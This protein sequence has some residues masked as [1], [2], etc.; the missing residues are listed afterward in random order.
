MDLYLNIK[1]R[2]E[3]LGLSQEELAKETGYTSR[4]SIA[5]IESGKVDL[6]QS[7]IEIFAKALK[8]TPFYLMGWEKERE[9]RNKIV[10]GM[11]ISSEEKL[12]FIKKIDEH[13]KDGMTYDEISKILDF[14]KLEKK[15]SSMIFEEDLMQLAQK[16]ENIF[17][18]LANSIN[19]ITEKVFSDSNLSFNEED[20]ETNREAF[21]QLLTDRKYIVNIL[22][23]EL[24][25][26]NCSIRSDLK[27]I[28][29]TIAKIREIAENCKKENRN[30]PFDI[31]HSNGKVIELKFINNSFYAFTFNVNDDPIEVKYYKVPFGEISKEEVL[32]NFLLK[33]GENFFNNTEVSMTVKEKLIKNFNE[34]FY[35]SKFNAEKNE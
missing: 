21:A 28:N 33:T 5:K 19:S 16:D 14:P 9:F 23:R 7:K 3:E 20:A 25:K 1:K 15:I 31:V 22:S 27:K 2:R 12:D 35:K 24:E 32:Y 13:L 30:F 8:T 17:N 26:Y 4:T 11:S 6:P 10:H 18:L 29:F 34:L